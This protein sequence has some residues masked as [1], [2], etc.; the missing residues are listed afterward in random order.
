MWLWLVLR[1]HLRGMVSCE[2]FKMLE[3][4]QVGVSIL[5]LQMRKEELGV[6]SHRS[7][8]HPKKTVLIGQ[9]LSSFMLSPVAT[10]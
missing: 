4:G 1:K 3:L 2:P 7:T 9:R 10:L 8:C 6:L 5:I